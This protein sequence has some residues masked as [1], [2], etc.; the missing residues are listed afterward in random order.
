M[1]TISAAHSQP[2]PRSAQRI[3]PPMK[4]N[5]TAAAAI[6]R[7]RNARSPAPM[8]MPSKANAA[9]LTG[10]MTA[11]NSSTNAPRDTT[12][13]SALKID[14]RG[15]RNSTSSAPNTTLSWMLMPIIRTLAARAIAGR[16]APSSLA[17][18]AWPAIATA[19]SARASSAQISAPIWCEATSVVPIRAANT[20]ASTN[21]PRKAPVRTNICKPTRA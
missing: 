7:A 19:S 17:T 21:A 6:A 13:G 10:C 5:T 18:I 11:T 15:V 12:S 3:A 20:A 9:A 4:A 8:K 2:I 16:P 14:A 1:N